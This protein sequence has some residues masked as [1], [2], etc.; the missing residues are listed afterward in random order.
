MEHEPDQGARFHPIDHQSDF[1]RHQSRRVCAM[2]SRQGSRTRSAVLFVVVLAAIAALAWWWSGSDPAALREFGGL[3]S[4]LVAGSNSTPSAAVSDA[5]S[6]LDSGPEVETQSESESEADSEEIVAISGMPDPA[7]GSDK[8]A[9]AIAYPL[10]AMSADSTLESSDVVPALDD[11]LKPKAAAMFL[12]STDF[13][14]HFV[15]TVDNLGRSFAP[16]SRWPVNPAP[17]RFAFEEQDGRTYIAP[18]NYKRYVPLVQLASTLDT[19]TVID[20]YVRMYP[21][22]QA[23]YAELGLPKVYFNDRLIEVIDL[24]LASPEPSGPVEVEHTHVPNAPL[25]L[26]PWV[27]YQ[28]AD[29]VLDSLA[30][31]QKI[32][33][34]VGPDNERKLKAKLAELRA[35]LLTRVL[36][37][38]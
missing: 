36:P 9:L 15:A 25:P 3:P 31:G 17:N 20:L 38:Q 6:A 8:Q 32:M 21:Q 24:L 22:L 14:H 27:N 37:G 34:R 12:Q 26:R 11:L 10:P 7:E 16:A 35:E 2:T 33:V 30:A 18:D 5:V 28:F 4:K 19:R 13:P 29:P 1:H 23:A